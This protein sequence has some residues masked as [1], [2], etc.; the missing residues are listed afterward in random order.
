MTAVP[1]CGG[2][3]RSEEEQREEGEEKADDDAIEHRAC[4]RVA[5]GRCVT[6][7]APATERV[8]PLLLECARVFLICAPQVIMIRRVSG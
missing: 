5:L 7:T 3:G 4:A 1:E 2:L 6:G 8:D